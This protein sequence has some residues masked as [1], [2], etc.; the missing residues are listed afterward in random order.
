[1]GKTKAEMLE[2]KK[3]ALAKKIFLLLQ[4]GEKIFNLYHQT[5]RLADVMDLLD[6]DS[7]SDF[8]VTVYDNGL[9]TQ[10]ITIGFGTSSVWPGFRDTF[11]LRKYLV[12][13]GAI[14]S[15]HDFQSFFMRTV[16]KL[17]RH[18]VDSRYPL[19]ERLAPLLGEHAEMKE[20]INRLGREI[21]AFEREVIA[22]KRLK[23]QG[24]E[25]DE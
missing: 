17:R 24:K 8:I 12:S 5:D 19:Y 4:H 14:A 21:I 9:K 6:L 13:S 15:D 16:P 11:D 7:K 10:V 20:E 23:R 3:E 2:E 18:H 1:M 25:A 22:E